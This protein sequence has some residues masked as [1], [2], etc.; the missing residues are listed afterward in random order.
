ML[1]SGETGEGVLLV[2]HGRVAGEVL[3]GWRAVFAFDGVD[4]WT[5]GELEAGCWVGL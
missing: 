3:G 1:V 5:A 2:A 4:S